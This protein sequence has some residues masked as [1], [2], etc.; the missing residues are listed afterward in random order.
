MIAQIPMSVP[1]P[2]T[3]LTQLIRFGSASL[4]TSMPAVLASR[5]QPRK[6]VLVPLQCA[7]CDRVERRA[8]QAHQS[9]ARRIGINHPGRRRGRTLGTHPHSHRGQ[10]CREIAVEAALRG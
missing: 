7:H 3:R 4:G 9:A 2:N 6:Q 8:L 10:R 5:P 1:M